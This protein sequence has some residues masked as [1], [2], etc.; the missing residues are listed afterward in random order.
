V[1]YLKVKYLKVKYL[2]VRVR[3]LEARSRV[4]VLDLLTDA[5]KRA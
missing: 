1:K 3:W 5:L 4:E 2:K